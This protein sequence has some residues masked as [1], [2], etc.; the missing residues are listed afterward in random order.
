MGPLQRLVSAHNAGEIDLSKE[1]L[2]RLAD[3][4]NCSESTVRY[5]RKKLGIN[6]QFLWKQLLEK[7]KMGELDLD[8]LTYNEIRSI[9]PCTDKTV[10]KAIDRGIE[11]GILKE[12]KPGVREGSVFKTVS[13]KEDARIVRQRWYYFRRRFGVFKT[14]GVIPEFVGKTRNEIR[15]SITA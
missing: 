8:T 6:K 3:M 4:Y 15:R 10:K 14:W 9:F 1:T 11:E 12:R 7:H 5:A 13:Q 2:C